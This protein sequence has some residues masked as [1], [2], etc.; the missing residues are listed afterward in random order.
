MSF[1]PLGPTSISF[2]G[3]PSFVALDNDGDYLANQ[4]VLR[5]PV[6]VEVPGVYFFLLTNRGNVFDL[7]AKY[8][9]LPVGDA[10]GIVPISGITLRSF[11][12]NLSVVL[13][14]SMVR[15]SG[16]TYMLEWQGV[17]PI[18]DPTYFQSV[19]TEE[20]TVRVS[21]TPSTTSRTTLQFWNGSNA[22][23]AYMEVPLGVDV[24]LSLPRL[25]YAV[26]ATIGDPFGAWEGL[27]RMRPSPSET[28][29]IDMVPVGP[30]EDQIWIGFADWTRGEARS[31]RTFRGTPSA[32]LFADET[33]DGNGMLTDSEITVYGFWR[34]TRP[35]VVPAILLDGNTVTTGPWGPGAGVGQGPVV[36]EPDLGT[37]RS[38]PVSVSVPNATTHRVQVIVENPPPG[39]STV[40]TF[41]WPRGWIL[42]STDNQITTSPINGNVTRLEVWHEEASWTPVRR[43]V[44]LTVVPLPET[45]RSTPAMAGPDW[46][47]TIIIGSFVAVGL[48]FFGVVSQRRRKQD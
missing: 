27:V 43:F 9:E 13:Q 8:V 29:R 7:V 28:V 17:Y 10:V 30:V 32:R 3:S 18:P 38:G 39:A 44:N 35:L 12:G 11:T 47:P 4:L 1:G 15:E 21:G 36:S 23:S 25:D 22:Y 48:G 2:R 14:I 20:V 6:H 24:R 42:A 45:P 40:V 19:P 34:A 26:L 33:S 5:V 31:S 37:V 46:I 41:A 16:L